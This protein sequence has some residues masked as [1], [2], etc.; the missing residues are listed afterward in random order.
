[1]LLVLQQLAQQNEN[2]LVSAHILGDVLYF[3]WDYYER[4]VPYH[5]ASNLPIFFTVPGGR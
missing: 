3:R 2:N 5:S 4:S 1:M